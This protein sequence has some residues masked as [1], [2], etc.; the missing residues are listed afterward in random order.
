MDK[1][2]DHASVGVLVW[3]DKRLLLIERNKFPFGFA[4]PAGHVDGDASFEIAAKRELEEEVGLQTKSLKLV[5]AGRRENNCRREGGSWHRW[6]IYEA[7]TE[8][9]VKPS[10]DETKSFDWFDG[11]RIKKLQERT[12]RYLAEKINESDWQKQP[13]LEIFWYQWFKELKEE[14]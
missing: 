5:F 14:K 8:G 10:Q 11:E 3:R 12:K 1:T 9:E 2:C 6:K 4:P 13:G 7:E